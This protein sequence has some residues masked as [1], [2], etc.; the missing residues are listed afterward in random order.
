MMMLLLTLWCTLAQADAETVGRYHHALTEVSFHDFLL[1]K[2]V[3]LTAWLATPVLTACDE[4]GGFAPELTKHLAGYV[5]A[6]KDRSEGRKLAS[7]KFQD[8][9]TRFA[10]LEI[11]GTLSQ[12]DP[13]CLNQFRQHWGDSDM[14]S[15]LPRLMPA[16]L[17]GWSPSSFCQSAHQIWGSMR[18]R[19]FQHAPGCLR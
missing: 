16:T 14:M 11:F 9:R 18:Q 2:G 4:V 7:D 13:G 15:S 1:K 5:A 12:T 6:E 19:L 17:S 10:R 3:S 8:E